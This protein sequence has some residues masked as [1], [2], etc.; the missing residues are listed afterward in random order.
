MDAKLILP[1]AL[2]KPSG[3]SLL[4]FLTIVLILLAI[5]FATFAGQFPQESFFLPIPFGISALMSAALGYRVVPLLRWLKT[6]QVIQED[7]PQ[8]H[9]KKREPRR[10][11]AYFLYLRQLLLP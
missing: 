11:G 10:W 4:L 8:T 6:E 7:G 1:T 3:T 2:K 5:A 9:L